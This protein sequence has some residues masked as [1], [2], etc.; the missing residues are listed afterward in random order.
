MRAALPGNVRQRVKRA[1]NELSVDPR[2]PHSDGLDVIDLAVPDGMEM[3]RLRLD[4]WR[5]VYAVSDEEGWVW[6]LAIHR[7]PP[8]DY[9]DLHELAVCRREMVEAGCRC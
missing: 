3:R 7:R 8:Y 2:P 6:V 4:T 9:Q 1:I 5:V